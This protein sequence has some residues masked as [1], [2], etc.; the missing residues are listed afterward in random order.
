MKPTVVVRAL[1]A[2]VLIAP[3]GKPRSSS[4][5]PSRTLSVPSVAT[6]E[7]RRS[8]RM[9][10]VLKMPVAR[11]TPTIA[12]APSTRVGPDMLGVIV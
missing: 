7:G 2:L 3:C 11:P 10:S 9:S 1:V 5:T 8:T 12:S 4:E 6:I